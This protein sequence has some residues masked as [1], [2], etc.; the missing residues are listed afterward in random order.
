MFANHGF[1]RVRQMFADQFEPDADNFVYRGS[2]KGAPIRVSAAERDRYVTTSNNFLKYWSW[3]FVGSL[4]VLA[5]LVATYAAQTAT[6]V[7]DMTFYVGFGV[8]LSIFMV[9]YFWAWYLPARELRHRGTVG[10]PRPRA[11]MRQRMLAKLTYGE[12]IAIGGGA[13]FAVLQID[14]SDP[15]SAWNAFWIIL[16]LFAVVTS[17]ITAFRKWRFDSAKKE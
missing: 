11:E 9:G 2:R 6:D 5:L 1:D 17:I 7:S 8:A 12:I 15:F 13:L 14:R 3:S 4:I 16:A 10:E